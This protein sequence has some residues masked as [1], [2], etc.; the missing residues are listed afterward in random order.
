M[1]N[2]SQFNGSKTVTDVTTQPISADLEHLRIDV[3]GTTGA[4]TLELLP[5]SFDETN[6]D[7][8]RPVSYEDGESQIR[9]NG[10]ISLVKIGRMA[11]FR[12]TPENT[13]NEFK[14]QWSQS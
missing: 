13:A 2:N 1:A 8:W 7:A 3:L 14:Y 12:L 5:E 10:F 9:E 4:V 11:K 6:P